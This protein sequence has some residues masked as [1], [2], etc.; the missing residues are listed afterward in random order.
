MSVIRRILEYYFLQ[1]SCYSGL[2]LRKKI[3][4]ENRHKFVNPDGSFNEKSHGLARTM[5]AYIYADSIGFNDG[6]DYVNEGF[7]TDKMQDV[8]KLVFD[9]MEQPQHYKMMIENTQPH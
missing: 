3:L 7:N 1:I 5:L 2:D 4:E 8:F 6:M 9:I